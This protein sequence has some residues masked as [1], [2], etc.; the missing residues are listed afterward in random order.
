MLLLRVGVRRVNQLQIHVL[1]KVIGLISS[2][3]ASNH[4]FSIALLLATW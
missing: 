4:C 1:A 3:H 2:F